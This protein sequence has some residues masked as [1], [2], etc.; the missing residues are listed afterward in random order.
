MQLDMMMHHRPA[1]K[2]LPPGSRLSGIEICRLLL[3]EFSECMK[4]VLG[5][6]TVF[7][8]F[9]KK[10]L[11]KLKKNVYNIK[12]SAKRR[13]ASVAQLVEQRIRNAW[14]AGSSPAGSFD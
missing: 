4:T 12:V 2:I 14:V 9:S 1:Q 3:H 13:Q 5:L 10:M 7:C 6:R 8:N 11:A